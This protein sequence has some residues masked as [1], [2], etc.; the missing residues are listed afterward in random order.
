MSKIYFIDT[1]TCGLYGM[2]VLIQWQSRIDGIDSKISLHSIW[3]VPFL[4]TIALIDEFTQNDLVF[5]NATF[6][7]FHLV[8]IYTTFVSFIEKFPDKI[9]EIPEDYI[10]ELAILEA[11]SRDQKCLKPKGCVD[12]F[13][14][15]R[16]TE[17]Q[18]TMERKAIVIK[19]VHPAI[20]EALRTELEKRIPLKAIYFARRKKKEKHVW[21]IRENADFPAFN[22]LV[23]KFSASAALK[24]LAIDALGVEEDSVMKFFDVS[25]DD[26]ALPKE[27][28]YAPYAMAGIRVKTDKK[29]DVIRRPVLRSTGKAPTLQD[30]IDFKTNYEIGYNKC[31]NWYETWPEKIQQHI[32]HWHYNSSARRYA[33]D[34]IHY[35]RGLYDFFGKDRELDFQN[36]D[37]VLACMVASCRWKGYAIDIQ[38]IKDQLVDS[39]IKAKLAPTAPRAVLK[40]L[41]EVMEDIEV[42]IMDGC[43]S[44]RTLEDVADWEP[45]ENGLEH[46]A[47]RRAKDV[48]DARHAEKEVD[49]YTKLLLAGRFHASF[50]ITGTLSNRMSGADK[51]NPQG[52]KHTTEVRECFPLAFEED[53]E[54][55]DGGDFDAFEVNIAVA[56]YGDKKL[57]FDLSQGKK[58]HALFGEEVFEK[59][60]EDIVATKDT[61]NDLYLKG[62]SG[63]FSQIYGGNAHTLTERMGV[64]ED[65]AKQAEINWAKKY[66]TLAEERQKV[67][68][69]FQ[70]MKQPNGVGTQVIWE[71]PDEYVENMFGFRRYFTL[72]NRV[73]KVLFELS[74]NPPEHFMTTDFR[75]N[76]QRTIGRQQTILGALQSALYACAFQIQAQNMRAACNH[77]IQST[78]SEIT[79]RLQVLLW[80]VF[81]PVGFFKWIIRLLNVHDEIMAPRAKSLDGSKIKKVVD[82]FIEEYKKIIPLLKM[83]WKSGI[84]SWAGKKG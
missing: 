39:A 51:L 30:V 64:N 58:I 4:D 5:F 73:C 9:H 13:L 83:D 66:P 61:E 46:P 67:F 69:R 1:E 44:A 11:E 34:D 40:Y 43:T 32:D 63:V 77:E 7:W 50:K 57:E 75:I 19:K 59:S 8:K 62:K 3:K 23:L 60:Y 76:I 49:L 65:V 71:D 55:L 82:G 35:T 14:E 56:K 31:I 18:S 54:E 27:Y 24:A 70:S 47:S 12:L 79:K 22:D 81:Q 48:I 15:A 80:N 26:S 84:D 53:E 36:T 29:V 33:E 68:D 16:K 74:Q 2:P 42:A 37:S 6:D 38:K 45:D 78:G 10:E 25:L 41:I 52:I 28:G 20:C 21:K 17:Y 72:E